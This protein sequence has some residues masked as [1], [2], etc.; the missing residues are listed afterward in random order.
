MESSDSGLIRMR[1]RRTWEILPERPVRVPS[2][3][4]QAGLSLKAKTPPSGGVLIDLVKE[5]SAQRAAS[6]ALAPFGWR[7]RFEPRNMP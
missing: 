7:T 3:S 4:W 2:R 6:A 5:P 1:T